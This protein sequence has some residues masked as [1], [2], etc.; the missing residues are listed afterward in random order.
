MGFLNVLCTY[1]QSVRSRPPSSFLSVAK[2]LSQNQIDSPSQAQPQLVHV[3]FSQVRK[4]KR[5]NFT[6]VAADKAREAHTFREGSAPLAWPGS[7]DVAWTCGSAFG[8]PLMGGPRARGRAA[9]PGL[10]NAVGASRACEQRAARHSAAKAAG[11]AGA[12][13]VSRERPRTPE[14]GGDINLV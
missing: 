3:S 13:G 14:T 4:K 5:A 6:V 8:S 1:P 7:R 12:C 9:R 2:R 11:Q 10:W